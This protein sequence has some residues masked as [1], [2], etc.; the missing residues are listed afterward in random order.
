MLEGFGDFLLPPQ[1][2]EQMC[3]GLQFP[4]LRTW[5]PAAP[6][7]RPGP[8]LRQKSHTVTN[9]RP[10]DQWGVGF[11]PILPFCQLNWAR[12]R[13]QQLPALWQESVGTVEEVRSRPFYTA[14][15]SLGRPRRYCWHESL[16]SSGLEQEGNLLVWKGVF[17]ASAEL[18]R[19]SD[20]GEHQ[21]HIGREQ[22]LASS[23]ALFIQHWSSEEFLRLTSGTNENMKMTLIDF[24]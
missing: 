19:T 3:K 13:K 12:M 15:C 21:S 14:G 18:Q 9:H 7:Y 17:S 11:K 10:M 20:E 2:G 8:A 24:K 23:S 16:A 6:A 22:G 5:L 4:G 1:P